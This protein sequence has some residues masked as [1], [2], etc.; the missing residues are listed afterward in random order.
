MPEALPAA[1][2]SRR[3][4]NPSKFMGAD[5]AAGKILEKRVGNNEKKI[6]L[7][8]RIIVGRKDG[9]SIGDKIKGGS[10]LDQ[11]IQNITN[12]VTN[13]SE[14]LKN[15]H[16]WEKEQAKKEGIDEEQAARDKKEKG[17]EAKAFTALKKTSQKVLKPVQSIFDKILGVIKKLIL[18]K[19]VMELFKWFTDKENQGKVKTIIRFF[20]DF[21]P[22]LL[23]AYLLFGNAFGRMAVGLVKSV[24]GF[25]INLTKKI[26]PKLLAGLARMKMGGLTK[27]L[28]GKWGKALMTTTAIAT[29]MI[30]DHMSQG[31]APFG[32]GN[33][34]DQNLGSGN[35]E[36]Q[37]LEGEQQFTKGGFVS[38]PAGV[39]R[40]P[41]KLTAGEFVMSKGAVQKYGA[42][43]LEGMNAAA[44]GTNRPTAGGGYQGGGLVEKFKLQYPNVS[45]GQIQEVIDRQKNIMNTP[46]D[47]NRFAGVH[48][49]LRPKPSVDSRSL[50]ERVADALH[51]DYGSSSTSVD[52]DLPGLQ[53]LQGAQGAQGSSLQ[54]PQGT[55]GTQGTQGQQGKI[56][57]GGKSWWDPLGV[58]TGKDKKEPPRQPITKKTK[59]AVVAAGKPDASKITGASGSAEGD[60]IPPINPAAKRSMNKV[61]T[62][63]ISV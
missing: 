47:P 49:L 32:G 24:G 46:V 35:D 39:D 55:Q 2:T 4:I 1:S 37:N 20:K 27:M 17:S 8:K 7:L 63:G 58:F 44:G 29:P 26:I 51:V 5:H 61:K 59:A 18:G 30:M 31:N 33:D 38:G 28:G 23:T 50:S 14:T 43:T 12:T 11:S 13:I 62:L 34:E 9:P 48:P 6:T 10:S 36:D 42:D 16:Q 22:V 40:V 41:A 15:R 52:I 60:K 53:G 45:T 19:V 21:W 3:G 25:A 57:A 54:G 56:G